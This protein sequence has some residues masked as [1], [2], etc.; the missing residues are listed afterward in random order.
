MTRKVV[1]YYLAI[2]FLGT[3]AG[4]YSCIRQAPEKAEEK[5]VRNVVLI[6]GDGMGV[7]QVYAAMTASKEPLNIEG[8]QYIGFSHTYSKNRYITDSAAAGTAIAC[9]KKTKNGMIG[10]DSDSVPVRSIL[11]IASENGLATGLVSTSAITHA[12]PAAF[13]AHQVSRNMY[14]EIAA[15]FLATDIDLFIGGGRDHFASRKDSLNLLVELEKKGY[16]VMESLD[17]LEN[18]TSGKVACLTASGAN[19]KFSEGRGDM[20]PRAT[21]KALS[22]L[23]AEEKGFFIMIEASMIDW[24]GHDNDLSYV[25]DETLDMDRAIG[26]ALDFAIKDGNTLV[27]VTSDH[28]TGGMAITGGSIEENS[29]KAD[30]ISTRHTAVMVPVFAFG[31]GADQFTGIYDNT[32]IFNKIHALLGF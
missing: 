22:L 5:A 26:E 11:E 7:T 9:G 16:A 14:E 10:M 28:E 6:I 27:I 8:F 17:E 13:I 3:V 2:I 29:V 23:N 15:D 25:I 4:T 30:F 32:D 20:L 24:G 1:I 21:A 18:I 31:P 12:T 19:L